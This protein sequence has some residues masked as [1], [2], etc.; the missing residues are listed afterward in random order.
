MMRTYRELSDLVLFGADP[1]ITRELHVGQPR[2]L[3]PDRVLRRIS[4]AMARR[5][6][7][8]GGPLVAEFERRVAEHAGTRCCVAT[9]NGTL[10][11]QLMIR[12]ADLAGDVIVPSFGF[13]ALPHALRWEGVRPVFCDVDPV[14]HTLDPV[15][16]ERSI[17][18]TTTAIIGVHLWGR[19]CDTTALRAIAER[20]QLRLFYDGAHAFGTEYDHARTGSHG[21]AEIFSFHATKFV[22]T[23]EGGAVVTNDSASAERIRRMQRF[24]FVDYDTVAGLGI[25]A[26]MSE[27]SAAMG[28]GSL[29]DMEEA[30]AINRSRYNLYVDLLAGLPGLRLLQ[31]TEGSNWHYMVTEVDPERAGLTRDQLV[32]ALWTEGV[33]A[34]RYFHPGCHRMEPYAAE[35]ASFGALPVTEH[36]SQT[37]MCLPTGTALEP[38]DVRRVAA[39]IRLLLANPD[40]VRRALQR[41]PADRAP[42]WHP[43]ATPASTLEA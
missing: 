37:V 25:N 20:H 24:G 40:S 31:H 12:A 41:L 13:V 23:F 30:A 1:G 36:L 38:A 26:K 4:E 43:A 3:H 29:D 16:V 22:H 33:R 27:A 7:T 18:S 2:V 21:D 17:T 39:L 28:L 35:P 11:L 8:N 34:R 14:T 5:V 32:A 15:S 10:A 19:R 42:S 6:L 9:A